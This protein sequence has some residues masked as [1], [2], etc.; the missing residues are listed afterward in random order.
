M[1]AMQNSTVSKSLCVFITLPKFSELHL[2]LYMRL[3]L[4][5]LLAPVPQGTSLLFIGHPSYV[6]SNS[7]LLSTLLM[8]DA[9]VSV[10]H[11]NRVSSSLLVDS[12]GLAI[13]GSRPGG[14]EVKPAT[15]DG[16]DIPH[17]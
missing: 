12:Q 15:H 7:K 10:T 16:E 17:H 5:A 4:A 6:L 11:L 9:Y 14:C 13:A 2:P 8:L 1:L 3:V